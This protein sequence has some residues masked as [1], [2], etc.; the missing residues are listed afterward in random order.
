MIKCSKNE[1]FMDIQIDFINDL[2]Y[3]L[4]VSFSENAKFRKKRYG[5]KIRHSLIT[6]NY[7]FFL[8]VNDWPKS[9]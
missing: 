7:V 1:T 6:L 9:H 2:T 5:V 4:H 3:L 8:N